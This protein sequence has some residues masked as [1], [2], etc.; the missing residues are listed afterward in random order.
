MANIVRVPQGLRWLKRGGE[1]MLQQAIMDE[2][3]HSVIDW[4]DVP[5]VVDESDLV[6]L[7]R[8][9]IKVLCATRNES[10][11][12]AI[13][14]VSR[15]ITPGKL[16]E[17]LAEKGFVR[18]VDVERSQPLRWHITPAGQQWLEANT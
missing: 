17:A 5:I 2:H 1:P 18:P 4:L 15:T 10:N 13:S 8:D 11:I 3:G 9:E 6:V 16:L 7:S 14:A 12:L